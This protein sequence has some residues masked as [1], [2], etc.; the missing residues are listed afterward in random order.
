MADSIDKLIQELSTTSSQETIEE[1]LRHLDPHVRWHALSATQRLKQFDSD[2]VLRAAA[3]GSSLFS[4]EKLSTAAA[5][6]LAK[7][8]APQLQQLVQ[9]PDV[10]EDEIKTVVVADA[11]GEAGDPASL[12]SLSALLDDTRRSVLLWSALSVAKL[13]G[14]DV[15]RKHLMAGPSLEKAICLLDSLRKIG[16]DEAHEVFDGYLARDDTPKELKRMTWGG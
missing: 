15:L 6:V 7:L 8:G 10:L 16:T 13:G 9:R 3:G 4:W 14:F 1:G 5:V 2:L 12:Q 11:M